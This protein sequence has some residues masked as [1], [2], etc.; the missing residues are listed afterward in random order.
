ME[1]VGVR[2]LRQHLSRHLERV[3]AGEDLL[4]T[5]RGR[6]VAR[7]VPAG[8]GSDS[9]AAL[10]EL[11]GSTVP[12]ESL[13]AIAARLNAPASPAGTTERLLAEGRRERF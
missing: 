3:K 9:Y 12:V 2:E 4:V 7:L 10:A 6:V 8:P 1:S 13:S 5:E 11:T